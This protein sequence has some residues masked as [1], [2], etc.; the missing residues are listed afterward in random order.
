MDLCKAIK[1]AVLVLTAAAVFT[2]GFTVAGIMPGKAV[3]TA[4]CESGD[5]AHILSSLYSADENVRA[6]AYAALTATNTAPDS[7]FEK[8]FI[9]ENSIHMKKIVLLC[10]L[11]S[12]KPE[13]AKKYLS[14]IKA[15][16]E[17]KHEI[18]FVRKTLYPADKKDKEFEMRFQI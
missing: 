8:R 16:G 3:F 4:A 5:T 12:M 2:A 10:L 6:A 9:Y 18:D 7:F 1:P 13:E 11:S 15:D 14:E 17:L